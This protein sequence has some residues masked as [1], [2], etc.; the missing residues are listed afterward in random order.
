MRLSKKA[1]FSII[2]NPNK[3]NNI[4]VTFSNEY[5]IDTSDYEKKL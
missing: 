3:F 4:S 5:G 1:K 2:L